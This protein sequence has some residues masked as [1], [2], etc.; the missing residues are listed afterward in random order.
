MKLKRQPK[1]I[2]RRRAK[3]A[4]RRGGGRPSRGGGRMA[5]RPSVPLRRRL[6]G[7]L[8]SLRRVITAVGAV[9]MTAALAWL[10][11][12]PWLRVT[13]VTWSGERY[14]EARDLERLL[15]RQR[16]I[17]LLAL[18]TQTLRERLAT[19][20]A[21][22]EARISTALSGRLE[23]TIVERDAAFVWETRTFLLLGAADGT[24]FAALPRGEPLP[25][26]LAG[27]PHVVD[28]RSMARLMTTGDRVGAVVLDAA[29]HLAELD[30]GALGSDARSVRVRINDEYG[31]ELI[32]DAP[33]WEMAFGTYGTDPNESAAEASARLERQVTAV[34]TLFA[35]RAENEIGWVDARNPGKVYFRAKG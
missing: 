19:L 8:P 11:A 30:P 34:R 24:L 25:G 16:G 33:G 14:T 3:G 5:R 6:T 12:G 18:D 21:V 7:R 27:L 10:V 9:A 29:L 1:L 32:A 23:V 20:P 35:T 13:E 4:T 15:D 22:A 26:E 2:P 17:S 31:L 28:E